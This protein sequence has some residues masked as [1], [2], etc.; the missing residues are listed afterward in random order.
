MGYRELHRERS[1]P[2]LISTT[3]SAVVCARKTR[4]DPSLKADTRPSLKAMHGS[5][6]RRPANDDTE[7]SLSR[8]YSL[9]T[10]VTI[11]EE[12]R[13]PPGIVATSVPV[14]MDEMCEVG[15]CLKTAILAGRQLLKL[16]DLPVYAR[17]LVSPELASSCAS[18]LPSAL[19]PSPYTTGKEVENSPS[20]EYA[21]S[22][23]KDVSRR[24]AKHSFLGCHPGQGGVPSMLVL[25]YRLLPPSPR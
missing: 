10:D 22:S 3:P 20:N 12:G 9:V 4:S 19:S 16:P 7:R 1:S 6:I 14:T 17:M 21:S 15:S 25:G 23:T 18:S 13:T 11:S 24:E 2:V 8:S 5:F